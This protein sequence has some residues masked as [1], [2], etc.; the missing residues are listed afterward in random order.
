MD[1]VDTEFVVEDCED[2]EDCEEEEEEL[3]LGFLSAK[4]LH[5]GE[6]IETK[7]N[8]NWIDCLQM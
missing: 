1:S 5:H 4:F 7:K 8:G 2:D 6:E 3:D